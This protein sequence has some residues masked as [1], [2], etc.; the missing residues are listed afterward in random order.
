[1]QAARAGSVPPSREFSQ[2]GPLIPDSLAFLP[3]CFTLRSLFRRRTRK[4]QDSYQCYSIPQNWSETSCNCRICS[5]RD[6]REIIEFKP[7]GNMANDKPTTP[8]PPDKDPKVWDKPR[9][10]VIA[11]V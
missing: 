4:L 3:T 8:K 6:W 9:R 10:F 7:G 2:A 5:R 11:M 1:M